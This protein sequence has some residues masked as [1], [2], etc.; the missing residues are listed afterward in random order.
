[1]SSPRPVMP[2]SAV[3]TDRC[4]AC[5][6]RSP[7]RCTA[8]RATTSAASRTPAA[9]AGGGILATG[10]YPGK[11]R[12]ADEL[13]AD[14]RGRLLASSPA[15]T[16][17]TC[18]P[19][20]PRRAAKQ[21]DRNAARPGAFPRL[22]RL[23]QASGA[24]AW[25]STPPSSR[26]P[27]AADG[28]TLAHP[29]AAH[30]RVLDRARHRLPQDRRGHRH[31][32]GH[33]LRHQR[34]D[35]RRLQ[36]HARRP[37]RPRA[38]AEASR[39][40]RSSPSRST[41]ALQPRRRREPSSSA[42]ARRATS[43]AR[44]SSTWAT[45]SSQQEAALPRRRATSIPPKASPTRSPPCCCYARR[46]PA[47]RQ[48]RRPLGQRPRG[49]PQ[50]RPSRRSPRSSSAADFLGRVHI[51]LDY[52]DASINR[53]AAWVIGTRSMLKALLMALLEPTDMLA[54]VRSTPATT[55]RRLALLEELKTLPFA[56]VWDYY[57]QKQQ[58]PRRRRLAGRSPQIRK[59]RAVQASV[60]RGVGKPT[61]LRRRLPP[62]QAR[63]RQT[64]SSGWP[65]DGKPI[66]VWPPRSM[67][68]SSVISSQAAN[69]TWSP[70]K[71][72]S[73]IQR[74]QANPIAPARPPPAAESAAA[75]YAALQD[76][77]CSAEDQ[78]RGGR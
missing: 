25:I 40:T 44:T 74:N 20:T 15:S 50:R 28:F 27:M 66:A 39:S 46:T 30:P 58:R 29:D 21:V 60:K 18:T 11:A 71:A 14:A 48:P 10:N 64:V 38:S 2:S 55:P 76:Q 57:C 13:R 19:S 32:P 45:P 1:M 51:G 61:T 56:A 43:S 42:S 23:G 73:R 6:P 31:G 65:R 33:A 4:S 36:G 35:P 52:F 26:H 59:D 68:R 70:A 77:P 41:R 54:R 22:D 7:S 62:Y 67:E 78:H 47:A 24:S 8:G 37:H 34:L 3:D 49:D 72:A 69:Q 5:W 9:C 75:D 53:V 17:S 63:R 12:T 16:A